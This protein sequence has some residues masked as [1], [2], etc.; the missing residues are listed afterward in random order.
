MNVEK[1]LELM[2]DI[3]GKPDADSE[4]E[5]GKLEESLVLFLLEVIRARK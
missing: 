2:A 4:G 5:E 3:K 1:L